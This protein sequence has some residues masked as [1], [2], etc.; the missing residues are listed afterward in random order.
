MRRIVT[1]GELRPQ[2]WD[3]GAGVTRDIVRWPDSADYEIRVSLADLTAAA[4][5]SRFAGFRRW[6]FLAGDAPIT[7]DVGGLRHELVALGDHLEVPGDVAISCAR[8]PAPTRLLNLLVRDGT[9]VQ[10]GRGPCPWPVR[11]AFA[12]S[13][14]PGLP[15]DHAIVLEPP[16]LLELHHDAVWLCATRRPP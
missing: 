4:P 5:F 3:N 16:E 15:H 11:F 10:I 9:D 6:S 12:L 7:L 2:P 8:P 1:P 13:A 14:Q